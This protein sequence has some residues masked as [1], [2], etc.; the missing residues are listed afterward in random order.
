MNLVMRWEEVAGFVAFG[1][2]VWGNWLLTGQ[3]ASGWW[4][5]I[6]SNVAQFAYA[7]MIRS[8]SLLLN[9]SAFAGI[10]IFG[11]VRWRRSARGHQSWCLA[12]KGETCNCGRLA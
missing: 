4:I 7:A 10:N 6:G 9:A 11:I 5:R 12:M 8:P 2:N 3:N 1:L